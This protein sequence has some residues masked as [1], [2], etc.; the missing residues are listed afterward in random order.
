M[1][2]QVFAMSWH[3]GAFGMGLIADNCEQGVKLEKQ[4]FLLC[5]RHYSE[6]GDELGIAALNMLLCITYV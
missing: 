5:L 2:N 1:V 6:H 4:S 3:Y